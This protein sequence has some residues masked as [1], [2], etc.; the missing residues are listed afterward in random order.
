MENTQ[1]HVSIISNIQLYMKLV[2]DMLISFSESEKKS[3]RELEILSIL[4]FVDE[5]KRENI[6]KLHGQLDGLKIIVDKIYSMKSDS[7]IIRRKLTCISS[8]I[9]VICVYIRDYN[10]LKKDTVT[11][12]NL[13]F[14]LKY[15]NI[16]FT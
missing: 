12:E 8:V 11:D 16:Y 14:F 15:I 9:W 13:G 10:I 2:K 1:E 5:I 7:E 3:C 4:N 6:D